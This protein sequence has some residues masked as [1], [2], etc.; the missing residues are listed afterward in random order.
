MMMDIKIVGSNKPGIIHFDNS[1]LI[2]DANYRTVTQEA[3]LSFQGHLSTYGMTLH[4]TCLAN[5]VL[6]NDSTIVRRPYT[7]NDYVKLSQYYERLKVID[8]P[9]LIARIEWAL[10]CYEKLK[11]MKAGEIWVEFSMD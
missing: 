2:P 5:P 4:K 8:K 6:V 11:L 10:N 7:H 1:A 9:D 3:W